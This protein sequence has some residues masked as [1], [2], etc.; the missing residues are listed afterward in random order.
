M[1]TSPTVGYVGWNCLL[2]I[3][4]QQV[5]TILGILCIS[6]GCKYRTTGAITVTSNMVEVV[7]AGTVRERFIAQHATYWYWIYCLESAMNYETCI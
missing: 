3:L 5:R 1:R 2:F 7:T 4:T 6:D